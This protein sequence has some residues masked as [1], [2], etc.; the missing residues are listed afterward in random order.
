VD[1]LGAD[2]YHMDYEQKDYNELLNLAKGKPI[3]LTECGQL[4]NSAILDAQ[5]EWVWFLVWTGFIYSNNSKRQVNEVYDRPQT[6]T[7]K[8][9]P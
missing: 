8:E 2:V 5:P 9:I 3:A 1:I 7:H 6:L 4:P